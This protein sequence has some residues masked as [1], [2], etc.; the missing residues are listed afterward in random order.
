[1][2]LIATVDDKIVAV[3]P[4]Q[5]R[6]SHLG[7]KPLR[8]CFENETDASNKAEVNR[9]LKEMDDAKNTPFVFKTLNGLEIAVV[10]EGYMTMI[11]GKV[12]NICTNCPS[13]NACPFCHYQQSKFKNK[14]LQFPVIDDFIKYGMS[15]LHF[16]PNSLRACLKIASQMSFKKHRCAATFQPERDQRKSE[17]IEQ[18]FDEL[19]IKVDAWFNI[20]GLTH[21]IE[22]I[23]GQFF[24]FLKN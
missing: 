20:E 1:M 24:Y 7:V 10:F 23:L 19:G 6:N 16:G 2:A 4:N 17:I 15:L 21:Y 13:T 8:D 12:A 11:D 22:I 14:N 5:F 3:F 9:L 18:L